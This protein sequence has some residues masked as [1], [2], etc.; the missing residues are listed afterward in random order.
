MRSPGCC[1]PALLAV[2]F[3]VYL[4]C[5]GRLGRGEKAALTMFTGWLS[6][7][8]LVFS[9]M[10]GMVHPYYTVAMAP[11]VAGLVGIGAAWAWRDRAGWDGRIVLATMITLT[12]AWSAILLHRNAFG[13]PWLP[14]TLTAVAAA[15][16]V[17]LLGLGQ[18][19]LA[20]S[21]SDRGVAGRCRWHNRLLNRHRTPLPTA[22]PSR[23][24]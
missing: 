17:A 18:R 16:A 12:A 7:S 11:A 2:A 3:G 23:R 20:A 24:R 5:R 8:A 15:A 22:A 21:R 1:L 10:S 14:W 4:L 13:P 19:R 9:Y 6:V